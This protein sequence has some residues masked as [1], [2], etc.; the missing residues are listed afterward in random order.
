M[1][2]SP[3]DLFLTSLNHLLRKADWARQRL[4]PYFGRQALIVVPPWQIAFCIDA[5]GLLTATACQ[6]EKSPDVTVSLPPDTPRRLMNGLDKLMVDAHVAGNA[7]FATELSFVF[8]HLRWDAEEDLADI[9]GDIAAH[10]IV[11]TAST[12]FRWQQQAARNFATNWVEYLTLETATLV[13][14]PSFQA[15]SSDVSSLEAT[16][17]SCEMR[18]RQLVSR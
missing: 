7:E 3:A 6:D 5:Q 17:T 8:R 9:V 15:F 4:I 10:R 1:L 2:P 16:L 13:S 12:F 11:Q 18:L 14:R